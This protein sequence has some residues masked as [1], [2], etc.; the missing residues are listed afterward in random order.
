[1]CVFLGAAMFERFTDRA[2]KAMAWANQEAQRLGHSHI[3]TE[4]ILLGLVKQGT[5]LGV[6][7]IKSFG[8]EPSMIRLEVEKIVK[9]GPGTETAGKLPLAP[10]SQKAIALAI[11]EARGLYHDYIGTE[12]LLLTLLRER[13]GVAYAALSQFNLSYDQ[14]RAWI[15]KSTATG[16]LDLSTKQEDTKTAALRELL[17][18]HR[19]EHVQSNDGGAFDVRLVKS[20][21]KIIYR[22]ATRSDLSVNDLASSA[23]SQAAKVLRLAADELEK[24]AAELRES[25]RKLETT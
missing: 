23:N 5:G 7:A 22:L 24:K 1:M 19:T 3:E 4:H 13:E 8:V 11:Q 12:H 14:A 20:G 15:I 2:R 9:I 10:G 25:A 6:Q 17:A 21:A 16:G 18:E